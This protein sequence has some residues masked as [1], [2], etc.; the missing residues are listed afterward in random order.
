MTEPTFYRD[1]YPTDEMLDIITNW[2][3]TDPAGCID[4]VRAAW[5]E[6]GSVSDELRP[7]EAAMLSTDLDKHLVRFSTGGWSGN[8]SL[9]A[10]LEYNHVVYMMTWRLSAR[11][12]L[13]IYERPAW[14]KP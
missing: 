6:M 13:H 7:A 14:S 11:G 5:S 4:Y 2:P 10:A 1:G 8:E 3:A 12:G 9:I